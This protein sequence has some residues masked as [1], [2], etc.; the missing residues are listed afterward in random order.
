MRDSWLSPH[1]SLFALTRTEHTDLQDEN[2]IITIEEEIKLRDLANLLEDLRAALGCDI[3]VHSARRCQSLNSRV[4][5]S[6][7]SQHLLCEA[8]DLSPAGPD[9]EASVSAA[10]AKLVAAAKAGRF[11]FGQLILETQGAGREGRKVWIHAS[12]GRPYRDAARCGEV[13]RMDDG[14]RTSPIEHVPQGETE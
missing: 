3:D 12:L 2:R 5:S 13:F 9:D 11:R 8:A 1:F 7:K 6:S 4:G 10:H 14:K